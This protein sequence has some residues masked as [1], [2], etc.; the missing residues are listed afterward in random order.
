[1][2]H[3]AAAG[4]LAVSVHFGAM[5]AHVPRVPNVGV[6]LA[7]ESDQIAVPD[8]HE[9]LPFVRAFLPRELLSESR[10]DPGLERPPVCVSPDAMSSL[11]LAPQ[12]F[13]G[14]G[15]KRMG[16]L[17]QFQVLG[18]AAD[19]EHRAAFAFQRAPHRYPDRFD[20]EMLAQYGC[21]EAFTF[22]G[23]SGAAP[24]MSKPVATGALRGDVLE[25]VLEHQ[26]LGGESCRLRF[27]L[28][29]A[30]RQGQ[31]LGD[32]LQHVALF[33]CQCVVDRGPRGACVDPPLL[34]HRAEC[35]AVSGVLVAPQDLVDVLVRHLVL[36]HLDHGAPA[37]LGEKL[38]RD[39]QRPVLPAPAPEGS[40]RSRQR[41]GGRAELTF[42]EGRVD[43]HVR[44]A[45]GAK[46]GVLQVE[47]QLGVSGGSTGRH[48]GRL[49]QQEPRCRRRKRIRRNSSRPT[50]GCGRF[51]LCIPALVAC[52]R[53][54]AKTDNFASLMEASVH[55]PRSREARRLERGEVVEGKVIQVGS[56]TVFVDIGTPGDARIDRAELEDASGKLSVEVGQT[57]RATVVR[58]NPASPQLTLALGRGGALDVGG[59]QTALASGAPVS[60]KVDKVVKAGLEVDFSGVRAFCPASQVELGYAADLSVYEGQALEFKVLEIR[61]GGRSVVVSRRALLEDQR[62][63]RERGL[64]EQLRV[65]AQ[66]EG[67]VHSLQK[68]GAVI[69]LG[70]LEAFVHISEIAHHRVDRVEDELSIGQTVTAS[71]LSMEETPKGVRVRLSIKALAK[72]P[73]RP[74]APALDEI[75]K[76]TVSRATNF[77]IFVDTAKG[78]GLVPVRELDLPPGSDHRRAFPPGREVRVVL[79]NRDAGSGK[80]RFSITGVARVEERRN[81]H[82]F[83]SRGGAAG[84]QGGLGSL[85]DVLRAKL[86][87]P[88]P[89]PEEPP[90]PAP[91]PVAASPAPAPSLDPNPPQAA[92]APPPIVTAPEPRLADLLGPAKPLPEKKSRLRDAQPRRP[93]PDGVV[94]RRKKD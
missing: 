69:D 77:G 3:D 36:E 88:E 72:A 47:S 10:H 44:P 85:G 87:L 56:D 46:G 49:A 66:V 63:E 86:G 15:Q 17:G 93:D 40:A 73:A 34:A 76:G 81:Y 82:D 8:P 22:T 50:T 51:G 70:G 74:A 4:L 75:L 25:V 14:V 62:R 71:V 12:A 33:I 5:A 94:R 45:Q 30:L 21:E 57:I 6:P 84:G 32:S 18:S 54:V 43:F 27:V 68:H 89:P 61:D 48:Q 11:V 53:P 23:S 79:T 78:E 80:L 13:G 58:S 67:T 16:V 92:P 83:S 29:G 38:P 55:D 19:F 31:K 24:E 26:S 1:M 91:S 2:Q 7:E 39:L 28:V 42:E 60:G 90:A 65:G 35:T 20:E 37:L 59:L 41:E 52:S 64:L 9:P